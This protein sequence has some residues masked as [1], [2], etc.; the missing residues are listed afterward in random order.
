M[1]RAAPASPTRPPGVL[2][3]NQ[4]T[5]HLLSGVMSPPLPHWAG[6]SQLSFYSLDYPFS[7]PLFPANGLTMC[8]PV[9]SPLCWRGEGPVSPAC[10]AGLRWQECWPPAPVLV[11]SPSLPCSLASSVTIFYGVPPQSGRHMA[12]VC[13]FS[14]PTSTQR[15]AVPVPV[16]DGPGC[17]R[18]AAGWAGFSIHP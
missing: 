15:L 3:G 2:P 4:A 8:L 14:G 7:F 5:L 13:V 10:R 16:T 17:P 9:T 18:W 1:P 12:V 6:T 11:S